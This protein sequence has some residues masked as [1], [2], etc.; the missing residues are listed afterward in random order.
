MSGIGGKAA[1]KYAA[2]LFDSFEQGQLEAVE[3]AL[4]NLSEVWKSDETVRLALQSPTVLASERT[5]ALMEVGKVVAESAGVQPADNLS[6]FLALLE[7]NGRIEGLPEISISF[8]E[9]LRELKNELRVTVISAS[10]L[11]ESEKSSIE[12]AVGASSSGLSQV[13]WQVDTSLLGGIIV[14]TGDKEI[15]GSVRGAI[16]AA[17]ASLAA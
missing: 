11:E 3:K 7:A 10:E 8:S 9:M 1:K 15:D 17:R 16:S 14:R 5:E 6:R 13:E 12:Q 4:A 2:A